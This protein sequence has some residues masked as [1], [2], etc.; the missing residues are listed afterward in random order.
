MKDNLFIYELTPCFDSRLS[1][2]GKAIIREDY[3]KRLQEKAEEQE[4]S[5]SFIVRKIIINE[6]EK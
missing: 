3:I 2:Y 5:L 6:L 1:F 4:R